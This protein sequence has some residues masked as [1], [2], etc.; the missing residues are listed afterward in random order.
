MH[1]LL[2]VSTI[3]LFVAYLHNLHL[4]YKTINTY[5]S[6]LAYVH[7][8]LKLPNP[9]NQFLITRL[10]RGSQSLKPLY[11]LRLPITIHILDKLVASLQHVSQ[12]FFRQHLFTAMFLFAFNTF[13]RVGE[14][15]LTTDTCLKNLVLVEDVKI[16][17]LGTVP[18][19][20]SVT[21]RHFKHSKGQPHILEL[22]EV[23]LRFLL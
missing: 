4:S 13:A 12:S 14:I 7:K 5:S 2:D 1:P 15:A 8:I 19:R 3:A 9:T 21:F 20:V 18:S 10:I 23:K 22:I 16:I 6:A 17:Y 11:D